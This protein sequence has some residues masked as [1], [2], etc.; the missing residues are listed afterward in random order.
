M[1]ISRVSLTVIANSIPII[2]TQDLLFLFIESFEFFQSESL[3]D[4]NLSELVMAK[5]IGVVDCGTVNRIG[6]PRGAVPEVIIKLHKVLF[7]LF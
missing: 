7:A 6:V 2:L 5:S 3:L 4:D 1:I